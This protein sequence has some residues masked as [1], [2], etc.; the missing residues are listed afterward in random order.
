MLLLIT[1]NSAYE[2]LIWVLDIE[3][4][5]IISNKQNQISDS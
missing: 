3:Y 4:W 1:L 5:Y 2:N